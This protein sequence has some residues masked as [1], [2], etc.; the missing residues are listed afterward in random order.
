MKNSFAKKLL[1][2]VLASSMLASTPGHVIAEEDLTFFLAQESTESGGF[3]AASEGSEFTDPVPASVP[4]VPAASEEPTAAVDS[5]ADFSDSGSSE[6]AGTDAAAQAA[7][8]DSS[9]EAAAIQPE[10]AAA[11]VSS[12]QGGYTDSA[13]PASLPGMEDEIAVDSDSSE[14][15]VEENLTERTLDVQMYTQRLYEQQNVPT[16]ELKNVNELWQWQFARNPEP[17]TNP[18]Q[19][20]L[21]IQIKGYLPEDVTASAGFML[22]DEEDTYPETAIASIDVSLVRADGSEYLPEAPLDLIVSGRPIGQAIAKGDSYFIVYAHDEY[23]AM[24]SSLPM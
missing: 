24:E 6:T 23:N 7:A 14:G 15:F 11:A 18:S 19:D 17:N 10:T 5:S 22:F 12:E 20:A 21:N 4:E 8:V 13:E 9:A 2:I 16:H 3:G 1:S